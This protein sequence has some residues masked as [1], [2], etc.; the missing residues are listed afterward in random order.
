MKHAVLIT[1]HRSP[2]LLAGIID[3]MATWRTHVFVHID[4]EAPYDLYHLMTGQCFPTKEPDETLDVFETDPDLEYIECSQLPTDR[5]TRVGSIGYS[6]STSTTGSMRGS[7]YSTFRS[8]RPSSRAWPGRTTSW[9]FG[10]S[11]RRNRDVSRW[12]GLLVADWHR[13][14]LR[15]A[16]SPRT[17]PTLSADSKEPTAPRRSCSRR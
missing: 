2:A 15:A 1:A 10:E 14:R 4:R 3:A 9:V 8:T 17:P 13:R 12:I 7:A 11:S 16:I 5:W 6:S